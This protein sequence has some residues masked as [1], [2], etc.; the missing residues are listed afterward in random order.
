LSKAKWM[1]KINIRHEFNEFACVQRKTKTWRHFESST[2]LTNT[3]LCSLIWS[4]NRSR[5][6]TSWTTSWWTI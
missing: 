2:I 4:T 6:R 5:F 3:W 1:I